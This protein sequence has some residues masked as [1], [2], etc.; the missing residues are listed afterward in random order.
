MQNFDF[1]NSPNTDAE[2][3]RLIEFLT[4][5]LEKQIG[6]KLETTHEH[7]NQTS[8]VSDFRSIKKSHGA[9]ELS[10]VGGLA[11]Y[12]YHGK[13]KIQAGFRMFVGPEEI[14][15]YNYEGSVVLAWDS[16]SMQWLL[17]NWYIA[18]GDEPVEFIP[19]DSGYEFSNAG[20]DNPKEATESVT[21]ISMPKEFAFEGYKKFEISIFGILEITMKL[22][23][24][25]MKTHLV[26][27]GS[28]WHREKLFRIINA[29]THF[30]IVVARKDRRYFLEGK[31]EWT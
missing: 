14:S 23:I 12:P 5:N 16:D 9:L 15:P 6:V 19:P 7:L 11:I 27:G 24:V 29:G 25:H 18:D 4:L 21:G 28:L 22:E 17:R 13:L 2:W 20:W 10:L 8:Y 26:I 3:Q 1:I 30:H 31:A